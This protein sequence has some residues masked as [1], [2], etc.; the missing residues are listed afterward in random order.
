M[1][2]S[3]N[4]DSSHFAGTPFNFQVESTRVVSQVEHPRRVAGHERVGAEHGHRSGA[5]TL[6]HAHRLG[7]KLQA[8][9][10]ERSDLAI[11]R[12]AVHLRVGSGG[13]GDFS[14]PFGRT[15]ACHGALSGS[16]ARL[17]CAAQP[18]AERAS[19]RRPGRRAV[20]PARR[21]SPHG[22]CTRAPP[23]ARAIGRP[24]GRRAS[25]ESSQ[26]AP[27]S[28]PSGAHHARTAPS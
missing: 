17:E 19:H 18:G 9:R 13:S 20:A 10:V 12:A 23:T 24:L 1:T 3:P 4:P 16:V 2:N 11:A 15:T 6:C 22:G 7:G 27:S 28:G 8:S 14:Q 5:C 26:P 25:W 21:F